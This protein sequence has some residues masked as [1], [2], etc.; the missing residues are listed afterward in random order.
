M[1]LLT[2]RK[3]QHILIRIPPSTEHREVRILTSDLQPHCVR[4]GFEAPDEIEIVREELT[5][6]VDPAA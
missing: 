4:L 2:R 1:L 6:A 5:T 3:A